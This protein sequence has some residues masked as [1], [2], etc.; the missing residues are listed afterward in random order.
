NF[1]LKT[2]ELQKKWKIKDGGDVYT[3]FTTNKD[4]EKTVLICRKV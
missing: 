3:F 2:E 1:P 4:G